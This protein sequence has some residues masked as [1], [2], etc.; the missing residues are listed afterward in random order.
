[1]TSCPWPTWTS[2]LSD[3]LAWLAIAYLNTAYCSNLWHHKI[4]GMRPNLDFGD[5]Q[6]RNHS[7]V[8]IKNKVVFFP[9]YNTPHG[10]YSF[11]NNTLYSLYFHYLFIYLV[12]T[13]NLSNPVFVTLSNSILLQLY[14]FFFFLLAHHPFSGQITSENISWITGILDGP[15]LMKVSRDLLIGMKNVLKKEKWETVNC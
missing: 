3:V 8:E 10:H 1:M 15:S 11:L 4:L 12:L 5:L 6:D 2:L 13:K 14:F 9:Q 7:H